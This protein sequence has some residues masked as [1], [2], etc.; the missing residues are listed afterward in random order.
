MAATVVLH[1]S[2]CWSPAT[3]QI[4]DLN[5]WNEVRTKRGMSVVGDDGFLLPDAPVGAKSIVSAGGLLP[6]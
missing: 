2:A 4:G 1:D 5:G 6:N 3:P